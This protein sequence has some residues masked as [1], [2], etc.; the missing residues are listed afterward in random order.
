MSDT[1]L[2]TSI[3]SEADRRIPE[4]GTFVW[5]GQL[6][7]E[8]G[9]AVGMF[10]VASV[11]VSIRDAKS[12]RDLVVGRSILN[13]NGGT[14]DEDGNQTV[15]IAGADNRIVDRSLNE[16]LHYMTIDYTWNAG[17]KRHWHV[18]ELTIINHPGIS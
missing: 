8:N 12:G 2:N 11:S 15:V 5:R 18:V 14:L 10:D 1:Y 9:E 6:T 3:L 13:V 4:R 16:E 17:A 7:D